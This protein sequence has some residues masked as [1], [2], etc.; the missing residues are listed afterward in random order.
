MEE[1]QIPTG[2]KIDFP[3]RMENLSL[4]EK[5]VDEVCEGHNVNVDYYGNILIALTEAVNN[6]IQHG[7]RQDPAKLITVSFESKESLLSFRVEDQGTGFNFENL[8]DPTD[9]VNLE[10][11]HGRGV[12][13]MRNLA[14]EVEFHKEGRVVELT[15]QLAAS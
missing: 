5:L 14:D 10:K 4:V 6:A 7:N 13:L 3:S 15:F 11:P 1:P 2:Q 12:F 9:P 8:P